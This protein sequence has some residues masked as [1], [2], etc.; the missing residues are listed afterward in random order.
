MPTSELEYG[1]QF[2]DT[3]LNRI[4][5]HVQEESLAQLKNQIKNLKSCNQ[6]LSQQLETSQKE[7]AEQVRL[8]FWVFGDHFF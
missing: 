2:S 4:P 3:G 6:T 8:L 7:S 1:N 5:E